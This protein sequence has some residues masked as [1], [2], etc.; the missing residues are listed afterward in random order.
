MARILPDL[1]V[2]RLW[3]ILP[4]A[5]K[6]VYQTYPIDINHGIIPSGI[7]SLPGKLFGNS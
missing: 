3:E 1:P 7:S 4:L 2:E 5:W 6:L